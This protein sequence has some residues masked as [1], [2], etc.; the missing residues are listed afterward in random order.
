MSGTGAYGSCK[1]EICGFA[2]K[3]DFGEEKY[4]RKQDISYSNRRAVG[5][6]KKHGGKKCGEKTGDSIS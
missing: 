5:G 1:H 4:V 3:N 6:R 2:A